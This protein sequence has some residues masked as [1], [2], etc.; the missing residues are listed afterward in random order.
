MP[1][2]TKFN[3]SPIYLLILSALLG[4]IIAVGSHAELQVPL[5]SAQVL[6]GLIPY[7]VD[8]P[9][10]IFH[11]K[12]WS[13][14]SQLST[15][16]LSLGLTVVDASIIIGASVGAVSFAALFL[17]SFSICQKPLVS[18]FIPLLIYT[19]SLIGIDVAYPIALLGGDSSFGIVGL[20]FMLL[21]IGFLGCGYYR[22]GAFLAG[23][24]TS[25]H[26]VMGAFCTLV[27]CISIAFNYR[28]LRSH[29]RHL[30]IFFVLGLTCTI[31]SLLWQM[32]LAPQIT[33]LDYS[34]KRTYLEAFIRNFDYHRTVGTWISNGVLLGVFISAL[35][36]AI[37]RQREIPPGTKLLCHSIITS[38]A[39]AMLFV[40]AADLFPQLYFLKVII[41]WRYMNYANLC[42]IPVS[43]S[44]LAADFTPRPKL[45]SLAFIALLL[46][47]YRW[48]VMLL[49]ADVILYAIHVLTALS[50]I[51][52]NLPDLPEK[53]FRFIKEFRT[54]LILVV[55][56]I[57]TIN[58]V[59]PALKELP[60]QR[61]RLTAERYTELI[62]TASS[63]PGT[64]LTA[65]NLHLIQL[66]TRRPVLLDGG[67]LDIFPYI[68]DT[69]PRFNEI[70]RDVYGL[71][72]F[73]APAA[74]SRNLG[75][76]SYS[77]QL[78]W[79][80]RGLDEWLK[81]RYKFGVTDILTPDTWSLSLPLIAK[82]SKLKLY[83]IPDN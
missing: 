18:F 45:R 15:I 36:Y 54:V 52:L 48:R 72:V 31:A 44:I 68:L 19:Y 60:Y 4:G 62:Q 33:S 74:G 9:F 21:T 71:D 27:A 64:I 59:V 53:P 7:P 11:L 16:F 41:P 24:A 47:C 67:A 28:E 76:A 55:L 26:P 37:T 80:R 2:I 5:E 79:E 49:S 58:Q 69:A 17:V 8:N 77:H 14:L 75:V 40:T 6:A 3:G 70:L 38:V 34:L 50:I 30:A 23:L 22:T 65:G 63:R 57:I 46:L 73:I 13:L 83:T 81:I 43:L 51:T 56:V 29:I 12:G 66:V 42:L 1:S 61:A 20:T 35:A 82:G 78:L 25:L 10:Y 32:R 39:I